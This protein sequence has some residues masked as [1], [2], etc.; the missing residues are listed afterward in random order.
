M[1]KQGRTRVEVVEVERFGAARTTRLNREHWARAH[2]NSINN[3]LATQLPI[4]QA[5]CAYEYSSNPLFEGVCNTFRDDVVGRDGPM[6]QV[7]SDDD[8]FNDAV[9]AAYRAVFADPDPSHRYGGVEVAKTWV[10]GLLLAGSYVNI[11]ASVRRTSTPVTF[12][13]R[14]IHAR[15]MVTPP[16]FVGDPHVAFGCKSNDEGAPLEYY[17]DVTPRQGPY[18]FRGLEWKTYAAD[19]VQHVYLPVE[20]EQLTG[21]PLMTSTLETAADLRDY[22]GHVM[23]AAKACAANTPYLQSMRPE[24]VVNPSPVPAGGVRYERGEIPVAPA[25]WSWV[26]PD[27]KQPAAQYPDFRHERAG[28]LGRPIHMPLMVVL[29]SAGEANFSTAQ[30]EGTVY[31]DACKGVQGLIERR[32][33]NPFV[34]SII[35][36]LALRFGIRVPSSFELIWTH[37]VPAH[38]NVEKFVKALETMVRMGFVAPSHASAMLGYDWDKVVAA[39]SK[40]Q[41][42]LENAELPPTPGDKGAAQADPGDGMDNEEQTNPGRRS[43]ARFSFAG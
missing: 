20:A 37:A 43:R 18:Q 17:I 7:M 1:H 23:E 38:S 31:G 3:D 8:R 15:R 40:C 27:A 35:A 4:L 29:L 22:D 12:G 11:S 36:E 25:G 26:A 30:Y 14:S 21:Y 33:L 13:W 9:E 39:R 5:R 41:Q 28:E 24:A 16:E 6:L 2:G 42:D 34:L 32:T 19:A 10:L